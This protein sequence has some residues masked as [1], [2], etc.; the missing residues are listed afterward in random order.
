MTTKTTTVC[1]RCGA[2]I[3]GTHSFAAG[4]APSRHIAVNSNALPD[5]V[6]VL[7]LCGTCKSSFEAFMKGL[8]A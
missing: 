1:D 8:P 4:W 7:D 6:V 2:D 5:T 3:V